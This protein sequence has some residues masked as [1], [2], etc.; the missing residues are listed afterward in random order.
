MKQVVLIMLAVVAAAV[1]QVTQD[2]VPGIGQKM[3]QNAEALHQYS[4]KRRTEVRFKDQSRGAR[5]ELVRYVDGKMETV[6][7][8]TPARSPQQ[9]RGGLRGRMVQKKKEE[10]KEEVEALTGLLHRYLTPASAGMGSLLEKASV[11]RT[12]PQPD[13]A[14][15]VVAKGIVEPKDSL[16]LTWSVV[17]HRPE[18]IE[19]HTELN[20]KP[21]SVTIE[22]ASLP[23][24]PFYPARTVVSSPKQDLAITIDS[25]EYVRA[26]EVRQEE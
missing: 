1:A 18:K 24:G 26:G 13:A 8:E 17:N 16:A 25:F 10:M 3:K 22:Y 9:G 6:P 20:G 14:V 12:G 7:L 4:Y 15:Q 21:V 11:S 5:V 19:V 23:D 2:N